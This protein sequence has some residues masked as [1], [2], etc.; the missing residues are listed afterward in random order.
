MRVIEKQI[1]DAIQHNRCLKNVRDEIIRN[2]D[3]TID[4]YLWEHKIARID[5]EHK[6]LHVSTCGY[7][8]QT[9]HRRINAIFAALNLGCSVCLRGKC[10]FWSIRDTGDWIVERDTVGID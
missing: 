5:K 1:I 10:S 3:G 9:T 6:Y 2:S 8:T 7:A 4:V